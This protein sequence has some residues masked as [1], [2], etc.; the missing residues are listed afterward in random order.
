MRCTLWPCAAEKSL[1][2]INESHLAEEN[3]TLEFWRSR[4]SECY[5]HRCEKVIFHPVQLFILDFDTL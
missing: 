5:I 3:G 2:V 4:G 1:S